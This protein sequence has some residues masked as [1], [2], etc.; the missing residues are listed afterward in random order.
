MSHTRVNGKG[1]GWIPDY[2]SIRDYTL[3]SKEV[4]DL[5]AKLRITTSQSTIKSKGLS[6][7]TKA[8]KIRQYC[9]PVEDQASLGSCTAN[10]GV[11]MVEYFERKAFGRHMT[12][13]GYFFIK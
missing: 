13:Q 4:E 1:T 6:L 10:A 7:P 12:R 3:S 8:D 11:G 2:P 9:P 5:F